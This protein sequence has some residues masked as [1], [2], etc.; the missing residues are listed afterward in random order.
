MSFVLGVRFP[1]S[2][3]ETVELLPLYPIRRDS[4]SCVIP[5]ASLRF[6]ILSPISF[7]FLTFCDKILLPNGT[8]GSWACYVPV[9]AF[10][11]SRAQALMRYGSSR[12][13]TAKVTRRSKKHVGIRM[14]FHR[15]RF[16]LSLHNTA[17]HVNP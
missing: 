7:P 6:L 13:E 17:D 15:K 9:F 1:L 10:A 2:H 11:G 16:L 14:R 5:A 8:E 12:A 3:C 4:S